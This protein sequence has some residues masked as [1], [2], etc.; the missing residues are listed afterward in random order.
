MKE[1]FTIAH[2]SSV[3][4]AGGR[5]AISASACSIPSIF[6]RF[7]I[8]ASQ[9]ALFQFGARRKAVPLV[10]APAKVVA[11]QKQVCEA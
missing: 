4:R 7:A 6:P 10:H 5:F 9:P 2:S 11:A 1:A 8:K 3:Y